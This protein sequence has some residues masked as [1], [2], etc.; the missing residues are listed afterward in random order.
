MACERVN[1]G[2]HSGVICIRGG[3]RA[4][5]C[6]EPGCTRPHVA[7]CDWPVEGRRRRTCSRRLCA[8]HARDL[9]DDLHLCQEHGRDYQPVPLRLPCTTTSKG[10]PALV[11]CD[12]RCEA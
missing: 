7:L 5:P 10:A 4:A 8:E 12:G 1:F 9:G 2:G 3:R 11:D 6:E